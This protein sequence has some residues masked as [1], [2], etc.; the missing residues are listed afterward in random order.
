MLVGLQTS[1]RRLRKSQSSRAP[2]VMSLVT[3]AAARAPS[4]QLRA[5]DAVEERAA[6]GGRSGVEALEG[7]MRA[8]QQ[9]K[10]MLPFR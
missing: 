10:A 8:R 1:A 5:A 6:S 4:V 2:V 3:G 9:Q 7:V